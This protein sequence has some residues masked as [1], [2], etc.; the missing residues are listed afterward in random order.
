M[1]RFQGRAAMTCSRPGLDEVVSMTWRHPNRAGLVRTSQGQERPLIDGCRESEVSREW[2][3][4]DTIY[5]SGMGSIPLRSHRPGGCNEGAQRVPLPRGC[6]TTT[7]ILRSSLNRK[8]DQI[9]RSM[10]VHEPGS[11][12]CQPTR[13]DHSSCRLSKSKS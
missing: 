2:L 3:I 4:G 9:V 12:R 13:R 5:G 8:L 11:S 6:C 7:H 1:G 10:S